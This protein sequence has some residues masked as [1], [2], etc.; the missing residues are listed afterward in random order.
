MV[1][2]ESCHGLF[3][4]EFNTN[5]TIDDITNI[6]NK[7]FKKIDINLIL[8]AKLQIVFNESHRHKFNSHKD[9]SKFLHKM[10]RK[11]KYD[12]FVSKPKL[13][14]HYRVL[15]A[16]NKIKPNYQLEKYM[17][18]KGARSR[19]GVISVTI[20]TAGNLMGQDGKTT[21][22]KI[23]KRGGCPM[24]C[25]Y[26]PFEKDDNGVPTQPRSYLSTEPGNRRA[27]QNK[28]HPAGQVYDRLHAL[29]IIGHINPDKKNASKIEMII[30]GGTFNFYPR[31]YIIWFST[32]AYYACNTYYNWATMRPMLSLE[33][34]KCINEDE[35]IRIIGLTIETRPDYVTPY[36]RK[37]KDNIDFSAIELFREIGVTR[38]QI[39]VQSTRDDILKKV[40]RQCTNDQNKLGLRRLKQ[41]GFKA[42]IHIMFDLPG[43]SPE[44]DREVVDEIIDSPDY[45]ADQWKLYPTETT[46][47][48][49]IREWYDKGE[50]IP[51][52]EDNT[53]GHSY[54]LVEVIKYTMARVPE[55]IRINRV[56]RDIPNQSIVGGL[57][58]SNL[59]QIVKHQMD[60]DGIKCRDIREREVKLKDIDY[61]NIMLTDLVYQSSSGEEH[62]ISY[63][64]R[65]RNVLYGFIRL[66]LNKEWDDVLNGLKQCALIR[67][68]HV[69]GQHTGV[70]EKRK[71]TTQHI[72]L[73]SKL[74]KRAELT[75]YVKGYRKIAVISGVGVRNYYRKKGYTLGNHDY[76]Y[77][78]LTI[79]NFRY[80]KDI[81]F[82]LLIILIAIYCSIYR[83]L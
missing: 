14:K 15:I 34:E 13:Y 11:L 27:T 77:K 75:A 9:L 18:L 80:L 19:S 48:T 67:E 57:V 61:N 1:D 50:Y 37:M 35:L 17:K 32:C 46:P 2:I 82:M 41:N 49:K 29:E 58:F 53:L 64:T 55:Y 51:Y 60:K 72:G 47:F 62:F 69:Y 42:D 30:S 39:G 21:N 56:V 81:I 6:F 31:E 40:N 8:L 59:R 22:D 25:H 52:A 65:D 4:P 24:D 63:T 66:R 7:S 70:G 68:L 28:H 74:L 23:V 76:M 3:K 5:F 38:V 44:I 33:E 73:G 79:C 20:F 43:S 78:Q 12:I 45:Q 83:L 71:G 26:C 16:D 54:K 36:N 10:R